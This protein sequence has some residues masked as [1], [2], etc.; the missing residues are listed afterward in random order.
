M[1]PEKTFIFLKFLRKCY[2]P[3]A[4][5]LKMASLISF[6]SK[7]LL[8]AHCLLSPEASSGCQGEG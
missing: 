7:Y 8:K 5:F 6:L 1:I 2:T 4:S 3:R